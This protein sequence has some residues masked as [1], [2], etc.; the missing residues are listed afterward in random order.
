[1]QYREK[2]QHQA[3]VIEI[4]VK[5]ESVWVVG[6]L[7]LVLRARD[8]DGHQI[9]TA[10]FLDWLLIEPGD[11]CSVEDGPGVPRVRLLSMS[12]R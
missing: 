9:G 3:T 10:E 7:E 6:R 5:R 1:M 2:R 11:P 8:R 12:I 4:L